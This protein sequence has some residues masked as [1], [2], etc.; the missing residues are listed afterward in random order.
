[1]PTPNMG[2]G[3]LYVKA[4]DYKI[5]FKDS[6]GVE[7]DLTIGST[8]GGE[9]TGSNL[10]IDGSTSGSINFVNDG[11]I[12]N[13]ATISGS[14]TIEPSLALSGSHISASCETFTIF[15]NNEGGDAKLVF[16]ADQGDDT[17]DF[18]HIMVDNSLNELGIEASHINLSARKAGGGVFIDAS[19]QGTGYGLLID[20]DNLSTGQGLKVQS[21]STYTSGDSELVKIHSDGDRGHDSNKHVGLLIDFDSTAGTAARALKIDSD[22]TTGKVVEVD[23]CNITTGDGLY[24]EADDLTTGR[25]FYIKSD[26]SDTGAFYMASIRQD[27]PAA[28][29]STGLKVQMDGGYQGIYIDQNYANVDANT[30][31]GLRIDIDKEGASTSNNTIYGI[32]LAVE[33]TT[34]TDGDNNMYGIYSVAQLTHASDAGTTDVFGAYLSAQ[35]GT[36][37]TSEAVGLRVE[38]NGGDKN[39]GI[40]VKC[41]DGGEDIKI[42][43]SADAGDFCKI[44]VEAAGKT[45][46]TTVDD[47]GAEAD[48][49]FAPDGVVNV[50][51]DIKLTFGD[52]EDASIEY[53]ENGSDFL[54]V[55]GSS[56]GIAMSGSNMVVDTHLN[57]GLLITSADHSFANLTPGAG[58]VSPPTPSLMF[59]GTNEAPLCRLFATD[60]DDNCDHMHLSASF[61]TAIYGVKD[62]SSFFAVGSESNENVFRVSAAGVRIKD[63]IKLQFGTHTDTHIEYDDD[64][65]DALII[66]GS[67]NT[68][69]ISLSGSAISASCQSF[70]VF[71]NVEGDGARLHLIA[72][73]G[74]DASDDATIGVGSNGLLNFESGA[75]MDFQAAASSEVVFNEDAA[76]VDF[77]VESSDNSRLF[78]IDGGTSIV[79]IGYT[80]TNFTPTAQAA[81]LSTLLRMD[82]GANAG[83]TASGA[84]SFGEYLWLG[85]TTSVTQGAVYFLD[86]N[87][88]AKVKIAQADSTSKDARGMLLFANGN[89]VNHGMLVRGY[90]CFA[91]ANVDGSTSFSAATQGK[92]V[93][94]SD[95]TAGHVT[96]TAP[97]GNG[98]IIRQVGYVAATISTTDIIVY[99][100]PSTDYIEYST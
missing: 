39:A 41:V 37:G 22:Q 13:V 56:N 81:A 77:R 46:F 80:A 61:M 76:D 93:Y 58:H 33:N 45:T 27:N 79:S 25:G 12:R 95:Q 3:S 9:M 98:E 94:V 47:D 82:A 83:F 52:A 19:A 15:N 69:S 64:G 42:I 74:D 36:N 87:S 48:I 85:S 68:Q 96:L 4:T 44:Q 5:Y 70:T 51:D 73:Q 16:V 11:V 75:G 55:S 21:T 99:W 23:A 71:N 18:A 92:A 32:H 20:A 30:T 86:Y 7:Y 29:E 91:A 35:G 17:Q 57:S 6:Y 72:D 65:S 53:D 60:A 31:Y 28:K 38:S 43:S 66:S 1:M 40:I 84:R 2:T 63:N 50:K 89:T 34:A 97:T 54:L 88:G 62:A 100:N 67:S 90:C 24:I 78:A 26:S 49:I 59:A 14:S 10:L 8:S